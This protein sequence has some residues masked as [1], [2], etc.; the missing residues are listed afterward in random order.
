M[1]S[2][3]YKYKELHTQP[4]D[5][6]GGGANWINIYNGEEVRVQKIGFIGTNV[7]VQADQYNY[8]VYD[9]IGGPPIRFNG[10]LEYY[11][12]YAHFD[13]A[14]LVRPRD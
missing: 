9:K 1:L 10:I 8:Y 11:R 5:T 7:V 3:D 2:G 12:T 13:R 4:Q 14:H 6:S